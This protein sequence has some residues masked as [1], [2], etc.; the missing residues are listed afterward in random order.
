MARKYIPT[1]DET[2]T[3]L[4]ECGCGETTPIADR[5]FRKLRWF[6]GHPKPFVK[7]HHARHSH[8]NQRGAA[9]PAWKGGRYIS[10][11]GYVYVYQPDHPA[12]NCDGH[13]VEHRLIA[14]QIAGRPLTRN[15]HVHHINGNRSD[16]R[17]ENLVVL[18]HSDHAKIQGPITFAAYHAEHPEANSI[19]G[20]KGAAARW[21]KA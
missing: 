10:G 5:T 7:G 2:P 8:L 12:A 14:E 6:T 9:H 15:E 3:G 20:K 4:C 18:S 16:N 17:P 19:A 11:H 13:V 21:H 1:P